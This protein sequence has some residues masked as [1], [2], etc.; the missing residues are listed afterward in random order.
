MKR[1]PFLRVGLLPLSL[2]IFLSGCSS[3]VVLHPQGAIGAS[4]KS[5]ILIAAT[6]ML[7]VVLPAFIMTFLFAWR[8][9]ASN[10]RAQYTPNKD[11]SKILEFS[12]WVIPSLIIIV[13]SILVW[14]DSHKLD[15]YK[16]LESTKQPLVIQVV[17]LDW[18]WLFIYPQQHIATINQLVFPVNIPIHFYLTSTT[19]I[20]S[21]FIPQLGSQIMTMTGMQTQLHLIADKPGTYEGISANFS[22]AGFNGMN[23]KAIAT[24]EEQF[25]G[26]AAKIK[27]TSKPLNQK[28]YKELEKPS[29]NNSVE[30]FASVQP[31]LFMQIMQ[32]QE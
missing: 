18:K 24:S 25:E 26:W 2:V 27:K 10:Q 22:G 14:V 17:S 13:L 19:V 30:Y 9:R 6:L 5:L 28:S 23:F 3:A 29:S 31:D 11:A 7:L 1:M 20:N 21:F 32:N 4:E 12:I 8:Y 15:P 16:P